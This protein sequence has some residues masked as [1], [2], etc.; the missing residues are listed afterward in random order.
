MT[1]QSVC[2]TQGDVSMCSD[3][4]VPDLHVVSQEDFLSV[5]SVS[6][7]SKDANKHGRP[8][9]NIVCVV[10]VVSTFPP[11]IIRTNSGFW[12]LV[13]RFEF[14]FRRCGN[15]FLKVRIFDVFKSQSHTMCPYMCM[16]CGLLAPTQFNFECC[17]VRD[18]S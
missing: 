13:G 14:D 7:L 3:V 17:G 12:E 15:Y 10:H 2:Q 8:T 4:R 5:M 6:P 1:V 16:C 18:D 11:E 9:D